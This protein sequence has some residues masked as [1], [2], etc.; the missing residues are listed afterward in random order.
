MSPYR[1][2]DGVTVCLAA[3]L[4]MGPTLWATESPQ[5]ETAAVPYDARG[6]RDPFVPLVR[7][8]R[9]ISVTGEELPSA[10]I[11]LSLPVLGGI[12]WDPVGRS[13]ALLNGREHLVGE[14]V[15]SYQVVEIHQDHVVLEHDG[16]RVTLQITFDEHVQSTQP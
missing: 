4:L 5:G 6:T 3:A 7:D 12:L 8:G 10:E 16:H 13:L 1:A 15:G 14:M 9:M 11:D 2:R